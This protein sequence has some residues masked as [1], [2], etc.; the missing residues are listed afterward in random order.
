[1]PTTLSSTWLL[2]FVHWSA[3][4]VIVLTWFLFYLVALPSLNHFC[5]ALHRTSLYLS[6]SLF[7]SLALA[8]GNLGRLVC[9]IAF[10]PEPQKRQPLTRRRQTFPPTLELC[11]HLLHLL[12]ITSPN[13]PRHPLPLDWLTPNRTTKRLPTLVLIVHVP[14]PQPAVHSL[15]LDTHHRTPILDGRHRALQSRSLHLSFAC[16][17]IAP[18]TIHTSTIRLQSIFKQP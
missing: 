16:I 6:L 15:P 1:M 12:S 14:T 17:R 9:S 11:P 4:P 5:T 18:V 10:N 3:I 7:S 2:N 13:F 8:T